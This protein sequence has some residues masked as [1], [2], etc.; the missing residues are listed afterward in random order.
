MC[1]DGCSL[2]CLMGPKALGCRW[3]FSIKEGHAVT[4]S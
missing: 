1:D 2:T 3:V 4:L